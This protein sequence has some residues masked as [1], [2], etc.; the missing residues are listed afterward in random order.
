MQLA[1]T[2][3]FGVHGVLYDLTRYPAGKG[4]HVI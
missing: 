1:G 2:R 3:R 4:E